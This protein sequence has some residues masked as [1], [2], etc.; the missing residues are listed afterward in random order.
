MQNPSSTL[1]QEM[2]FEAASYAFKGKIEMLL[3]QGMN[4]RRTPR[5]TQ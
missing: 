3:I 4:I 5:L 1:L 2:Y